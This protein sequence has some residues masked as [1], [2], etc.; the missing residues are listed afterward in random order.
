LHNVKEQG[1]NH[2][3]RLNLDPYQ[4]LTSG[5]GYAQRTA[6][7]VVS[8]SRQ[9]FLTTSQEPGEMGKIFT[10]QLFLLLCTRS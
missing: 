3:A 2:R 7:F 8:A 1:E 4:K 5:I 9:K 10:G 6:E